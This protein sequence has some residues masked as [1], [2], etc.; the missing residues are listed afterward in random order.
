MKERKWTVRDGDQFCGHTEPWAISSELTLTALQQPACA[1]GYTDQNTDYIVC[2]GA[3]CCGSTCGSTGT[4]YVP[5]S[6][7]DSQLGI[8][9]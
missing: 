7:V 3:H 9:F 8:R 5:P 2:A 1:V 6:K 4:A